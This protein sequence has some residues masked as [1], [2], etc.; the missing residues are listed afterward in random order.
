MKID[1][2]LLPLND[3]G[4]KWSILRY[5]HSGLCT[6]GIP[7]DK[8]TKMLLPHNPGKGGAAETLPGEE[9]LQLPRITSGL[10]P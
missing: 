3:P 2:D 7:L 4:Q 10:H 6:E 8:I 1:E 9:R 5:S